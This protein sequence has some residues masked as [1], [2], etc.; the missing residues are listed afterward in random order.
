VNTGFSVSAQHQTPDRQ[1]KNVQRQEFNSDKDCQVE[2]AN[3][4]QRQ[5]GGVYAE[6]SLPVS[7]DDI[8][9]AY[10]IPENNLIHDALKAYHEL[11]M[12]DQKEYVSKLMGIDV[13]A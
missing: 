1:R 8:G 9:H 13:F 5:E 7:L 10:R 12:M 4:P 11:S 3:Q 6:P 2:I